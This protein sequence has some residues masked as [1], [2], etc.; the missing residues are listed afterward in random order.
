VQRLLLQGRCH[1]N[2][3]NNDTSFD[4][5]K[6]RSLT[7][8][9]GVALAVLIICAVVWIVPLALVRSWTEVAG[10]V[11]SPDGKWDVV[12]M[13]RNAGATTDYSTQLSVVPAGG[14]ASR[15][16][17]LC[18][19]GNIFIADGNHG[20]VAVDDR[21]LMHVAVVWQSPNIVLIRFPPSARVFKQERRFQSVVINYDN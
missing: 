18:R 12:L 13:V 2:N 17:A 20:A 5:V 14:R 10:D 8:A 1:A 9:S 11:P 6:R 21:G 19:P 15:E 16:I 4:T 7:I 3:L